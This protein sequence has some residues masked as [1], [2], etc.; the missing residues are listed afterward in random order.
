MTKPSDKSEQNAAMDL[1]QAIADQWA[2]AINLN[3]MVQYLSAASRLLPSVPDHAR[4]G[5]IKRQRQSIDALVRQAFMEG[6]VC[7]RDGLDG[8]IVKR[9]DSQ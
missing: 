3:Q 6:F 8:L 5:F 2:E 7:A 4:E 1:M 9:E